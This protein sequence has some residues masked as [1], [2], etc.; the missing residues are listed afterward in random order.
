VRGA[1][2]DFPCGKGSV[3]CYNPG[4]RLVK[5]NAAQCGATI[6]AEARFCPR[7]GKPVVVARAAAERKRRG[8]CGVAGRKGFAILRVILLCWLV[9]FAVKSIRRANVQMPA[10]PTPVSITPA[11]AAVSE[12]V[13]PEVEA[14]DLGSLDAFVAWR[15]GHP[16]YKT[17]ARK[18][19]EGR[20]VRWTGVL[21]K[22]LIPGRYEL[23]EEVSGTKGSIRMIPV[24]DDAKEDLRKLG[25]GTNVVIE[26]VLMDEKSLHLVAVRKVK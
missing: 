12:T 16:Q 23:V 17:Q 26:G 8:V 25:S 7:C 15:T 24:T 10:T 3:Q 11:P 5:C 13:V 2:D 21:K 9:T 1:R 22:S 4:M 20:D 14:A 6:P 19:L 18:L